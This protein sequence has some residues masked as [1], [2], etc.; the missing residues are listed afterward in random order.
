MILTG[1]LNF[2]IIKNVPPFCLIKATPHIPR[3]LPCNPHFGICG[4]ALK[5]AVN[6]L[7][8]AYLILPA[9]RVF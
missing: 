8:V 2:F 6:L 1:F 3:R 4:V 5:V 9:D 7:T